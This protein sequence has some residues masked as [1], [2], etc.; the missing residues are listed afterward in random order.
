M[1]R[2]VS[3]TG[4]LTGEQSEWRSFLDHAIEVDMVTTKGN[5]G[6]GGVGRGRGG[7]G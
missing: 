7:E 3:G 6:R 5:V 1:G 2:L 4:A